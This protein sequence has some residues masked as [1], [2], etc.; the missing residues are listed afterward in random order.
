[1]RRGAGNQ[2][3]VDVS[4]ADPSVDP[5]DRRMTNDSSKKTMAMGHRSTT[6]PFPIHIVYASNQKLIPKNILGSEGYAL[7]LQPYFRTSFASFASFVLE[8]VLCSSSRYPPSP[9]F[10]S[11]PR[12]DLQRVQEILHYAP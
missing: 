1:M 11:H 8:L 7:G 3:P 4:A 6:S 2:R 9:F 10:R 12:I 5:S